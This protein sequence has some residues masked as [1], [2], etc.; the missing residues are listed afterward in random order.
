[1]SIPE[2]GS[3]DYKELMFFALI[4]IIFFVTS[5]VMS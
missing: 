1:M 5:F 2:I 3:G 4:F